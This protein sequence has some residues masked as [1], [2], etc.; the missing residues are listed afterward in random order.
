MSEKMRVGIVGPVSS[1]SL[2]YGRVLSEMPDVEFVGI[3]H[4]DRDPKYIRDSL[5]LRWLSRYPKTMAEYVDRFGGA[6][7]EK[8]EALI[9]TGGA[10]AV[11]ICT[12]DYL[13]QHHAL[14]ALNAGAHVFLPKPFASSRTEG[15]TVYATAAEKGLI[16][17]GSLPHRFNP[18][19]I[20]AHKAIEDGLIGRPVSGHFAIAHHLTFG[21]WKSDP[22]MAAGPEYEI[23]FY[24]FD[25][26][27]MMMGSEVA[28]VMGVGANLDHKGVPYIDNG[29]AIVQ[30]E[31]EA[32]ATVD[33]LLSM[34]QHFPAGRGYYVVGDEG[35][36]TLEPD[37]DQ[38]VVAVYKPNG[39]Q[40]RPIEAG[41]TFH[42]EISAWLGLCRQ[43]GDPTW[44][45]QE[46]LK[47]LD[48]ISAWKRAYECGGVVSLNCAEG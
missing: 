27:R 5:N 13:H 29:K 22:T 16:A 24:V 41:D 10:Q 18:S 4:L 46:S 1:Y 11:A 43:G 12:E 47:T 6:A 40:K 14:R 42:N 44:Q 39:V 21:S 30:F 38:T 37:G 7:Y 45:Q 20:A 19:S 35:A 23:G 2:H 25:L 32:M 26:M 8:P 17:L 3:A 48:V 34:H 9:E 36:L 28:T 33:M 31:N 15:E